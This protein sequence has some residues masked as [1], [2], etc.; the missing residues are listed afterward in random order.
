[1]SEKI[2]DFSGW[3]DEDVAG[4]ILH[5]KL[6]KLNYTTELRSKQMRTRLLTGGEILLARMVF[7]TTLPYNQITISDAM[8]LGGRPFTI[9]M[10]NEGQSV[11][12]IFG[13]L[14]FGPL[15]TPAILLT[16]PSSYMLNIGA[17]G[18]ANAL[19][20]DQVA[21][22]IHELAHVWQS[23]NQTFSS[24]Y[25]FNSLWHQA[26][27]NGA[28]YSYSPGQAWGSYNVEQQAHLVEDWFQADGMSPA[29]SRFTYI[30]SNIRARR[31]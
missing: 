19:A 22:F 15:V 28:A 7:Q 6:L 14:L 25:I 3:M 31:P 4:T 13:T 10:F 30:Q 27:S 24:A 20:S 17:K 5:V 16:R 18:F 21:T 23:F 12:S 8:G 29:S 9:P 2:Q 11:A 26:I 1:M